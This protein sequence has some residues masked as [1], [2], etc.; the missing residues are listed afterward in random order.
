[1]IL[2][3]RGLCTDRIYNSFMRFP[4]TTATAPKCLK[5]GP[6]KLHP[7]PQ[8]ALAKDTQEIFPNI[9]CQTKTIWREMALLLVKESLFHC[10][11]TSWCRLRMYFNIL[12]NKSFAFG[13]IWSLV[14]WTDMAELSV[15]VCMWMYTPVHANFMPSEFIKNPYLKYC[16][17][18]RSENITSCIR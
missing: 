10:F 14:A 12:L 11:R 9:K 4:M 16:C 1:M 18:V 8:M 13:G 17:K 3:M 7:R 2:E 5:Q 6:K 15:C